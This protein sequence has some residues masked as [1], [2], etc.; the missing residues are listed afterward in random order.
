MLP[1]DTILHADCLTV[2]PDVPDQS[3]D[4][5]L[6]DLPY[7]TT[8]NGW[9]SVLP[10]DRLW[11]EW[12]RIIRPR[13]AIVL[14]AQCPFDKVL[15]ASNLEWLRYEWIWQKEQGTGHLNAKFAPMKQHENILV[16]SP[17]GAAFHRDPTKMMKYHPQYRTGRA[18]TTH[19]RSD[20]GSQNYDA[21]HYCSTTTVNDGQHYYP[22]SVLR[23]PHDRHAWHPTQKPID[24]LRYLILTYTDP[25]DMVLDCTCG[26]GS[27]LRAAHREHRHYLGI[28]LDPDIYRHALADLRAEQQQPLLDFDQ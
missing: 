12:R 22:L 20:R 5:I 3:V 4:L 23:F 21:R 14:F 28:E 17:S 27:T 16:F 8:R 1:I 15:G 19:P 26:S 11:D 6:T 2:L 18:Y 25:G 7:G 24:L 10:L 9:D 13:G